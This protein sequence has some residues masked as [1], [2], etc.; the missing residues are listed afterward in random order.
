MK[1]R[2]KLIIENLSPAMLKTES[3]RLVSLQHREAK[4]DDIALHQLILTR[5]KMQQRYHLMER[6][7]KADRKHPV[8]PDG[9]RA[10]PKPDNRKAEPKP[11]TSRSPS[12]RPGG[13]H[14]DRFCPTATEEQ[15]QQCYQRLRESKVA[16][17][18]AAR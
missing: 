7:E 6:E 14:L 8:E 16:K 18:K 4:T 11:E 10:T 1:N 13:P 2:C 9:G 17:I 12:S 5:A 3:K 15:K